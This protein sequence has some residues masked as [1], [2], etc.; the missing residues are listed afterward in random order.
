MRLERRVE[1]DDQNA[2]L[3]GLLDRGHDGLGVG[4]RDQDALGAI[5]DAGFDGRDLAFVVAVILAGIGL[6]I[7]AEF[8][9]LGGRRLPSS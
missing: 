8:L 9:G 6:E 5:G 2:G 3:T 7:D 4:W 1:G